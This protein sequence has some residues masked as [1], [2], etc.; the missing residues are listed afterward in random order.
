MTLGS[1][2]FCL[3][4]LYK[5]SAGTGAYFDLDDIQGPVLTYVENYGVTW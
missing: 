5:N 2:T 4:R 1:S 3:V